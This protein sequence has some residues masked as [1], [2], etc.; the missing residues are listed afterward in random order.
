MT[1]SYPASYPASYLAP[2]KVNLCLNVTGR[3]SNGYHELVSVAGFT[4]F[5][6]TLSLH[7]VQLDAGEDAKTDLQITG[8]FATDLQ[9]A[10]GD[11]LIAAAYSALAMHLP[12]DRFRFHLEKHIPLGGGLGG[13]SADAAAC[14][15]ALI[16][17]S[18]ASISPEEVA[19]IAASIG[20]DVPVCLAPGWQLM[21]GTGTSLVRLTPPEHGT[22][23]CVLANPGIAVSTKDVFARLMSFSQDEAARLATEQTSALE[24]G[25]FEKLMAFGND[26]QA[27]ACALYPEIADLLDQLAGLRSDFPSDYIGRAMSGS[28]G[29]CFCLIRSK[30]AADRA[31]SHLQDHGIWATATAFVSPASP[32]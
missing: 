22:L 18:Q 16:E 11:T 7:P 25:A 27:P 32:L 21:T 26:L 17:T 23:H 5:G 3:R 20:A 15:R 8:P 2:A 30:E 24:S 1:I 9:N 12:L 31:A 19:K 13:G 10:G 14:L 28:G 29:S 6:D 4:A